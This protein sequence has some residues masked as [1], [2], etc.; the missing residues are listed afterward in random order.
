M[1]LQKTDNWHSSHIH[2]ISTHNQP[3]CISIY[4]S[5]SKRLFP[6]KLLLKQKLLSTLSISHS[7]RGTRQAASTSPVTLSP[8]LISCHN[9][10]S[11]SLH[12]TSLNSFSPWSLSDSV[13]APSL[14]D[15]SPRHRLYFLPMLC[16]CV[17]ANLSGCVFNMCVYG[18][19]FPSV[20]PSRVRRNIKVADWNNWSGVIIHNLCQL[21]ISTEN[22]QKHEDSHTQLL[23][24]NYMQTNCDLCHF[25]WKASEITLCTQRFEL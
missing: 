14:P 17:C 1:R 19:L 2:H 22:I 7:L 10:I 20:Q 21:F 11:S 24:N 23:K 13:T 4:D 25:S 6:I 9:S 16:V 15:S 12:V 8:H 5:T 18:A 3:T